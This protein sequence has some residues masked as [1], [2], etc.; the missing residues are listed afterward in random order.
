[1]PW[2]YILA[3]GDGSYYVGST[4]DLEYR[5]EQHHTGHA[6]SYTT[7]RRP[8]RLVRACE[9][10]RIDEAWLA[11]R[12]LHG[13]SRAKKQALIEGRIDDLSVLSHNYTEFGRPDT[14]GLRRASDP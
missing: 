10:D 2:T 9:F 3:C 4:T 5:L 13:W 6:G 8:V 11:E 14:T 12:Q 7:K 1:M